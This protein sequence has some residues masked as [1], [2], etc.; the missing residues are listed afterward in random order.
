MG[1]SYLTWS[2]SSPPG[3]KG[4]HFEDYIVKCIFANENVCI[5]IQISLK[6]VPKATIDNNL[7]LVHIMAQLKLCWSSSLMHICDTRG[8]WVYS[9]ISEWLKFNSSPPVAAYMCQWT[10]SAL[11][12]VMTWCRRGT[13]PL[14]E[15]MLDY[16]QL[17]FWE[18][19]SVKFETEFYHFHSKNAFEIV[20]CQNG[21]HFLQ[22][23]MS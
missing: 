7:A 21:S 19:I 17:D 10:R 11:V 8:T 6:F 22:G 4:H 16:C 3:Q 9:S 18:Q 1:S 14:P 15:P 23:E 5:L 12:Q 13:K 20:A 2:N